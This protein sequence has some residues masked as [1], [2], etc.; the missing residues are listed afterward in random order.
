[1]KLVI[2][3]PEAAYKRLQSDS[4]VEWLDAEHILHAVSNGVLLPQG[5]GDLVDRDAI[6]K[7]YDCS[8]MDYSMIDA[9]N[10]AQIIIEADM[11]ESEKI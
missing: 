7:A 3:I 11:T 4:G 10:D 9:L 8:D 5:H 1:M 6:Q 2:D